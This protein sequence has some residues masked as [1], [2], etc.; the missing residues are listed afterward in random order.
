MLIA[1]QTTE[2]IIKERKEKKEKVKKRKWHEM[3]Q[4]GASIM[5]LRREVHTAEAAAKTAEKI[6]SKCC[7]EGER[8]ALR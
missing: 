2:K 3:A 4:R 8:A 5:Q 6:A 7:E 1:P